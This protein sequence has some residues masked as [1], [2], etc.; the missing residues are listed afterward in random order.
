MSVWLALPARPASPARFVRL[1]GI[2]RSP[3]SARSLD[4]FDQPFD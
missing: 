3:C 4:L 1:V 2:A